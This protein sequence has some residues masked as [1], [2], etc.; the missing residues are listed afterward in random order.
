MIVWRKSTYS[1]PEANCVEVALG[2]TVVGVRDSKN[3]NGGHLIM[4]SA[5]FTSLLDAIKSGDHH[6][7]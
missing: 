1:G 6:P 7:R 5:A 4:P 3:P 2:D